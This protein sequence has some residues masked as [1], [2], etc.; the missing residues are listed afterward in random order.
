MVSSL[1][2]RMSRATQVRMCWASSSLLKAFRAAKILVHAYLMYDFPTETKAEQK[3]A[4]RYVR[5]LAKKGLIQSCF[6][7]RF[8]LTVH[9]PIAK[10]PAKFGIIV[11]VRRS[12]KRIFA[13][14]E[15]DYRYIRNS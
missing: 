11:P 13:R 15:L 10:D 9:S 14:N 1:P 12:G 2:S 7:H 3:G 6:W 8:A 5:G 4:E